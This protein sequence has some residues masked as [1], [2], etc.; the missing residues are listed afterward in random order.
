MDPVTQSIIG[1]RAL[2]PAGA[3]E[4]WQASPLRIALALASGVNISGAVSIV[5]EIHDSQGTAATEPLASI[6]ITP[7]SDT[8]GPWTLD[9]SGPQLNQAIAAGRP[10]R[11]LWL[12]IVATYAA[13]DRIE[14]L[15]TRTIT[16][17]RSA[18]SGAVAA[19]PAAVTYL[20]AAAAATLYYTKAQVDALIDGV[21][22]GD[23]TSRY[24][25]ATLT[26]GQT[27]VTVTLLSGEKVSC[28]MPQAITGLSIQGIET[29]GLNHTIQFSAS[30]DADIPLLLTIKK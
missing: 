21:T 20:T 18:Y 22:S 26:A 12:V 13:A 19:P 29:S 28:V 14:V 2:P 9:F 11:S 5:A 3:F 6:E 15:A 16:L 24:V 10:S 25:D 27:S 23:S 30:H 4:H 1:S 7:V 8:D 17:H